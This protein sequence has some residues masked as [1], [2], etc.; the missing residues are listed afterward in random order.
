MTY[1]IDI[2]IQDNES[3][4]VIEDS[5]HN[6]RLDHL[7][8]AFYHDCILGLESLLVIN[9]HNL[10]IIEHNIL[11]SFTNIQRALKNNIYIKYCSLDILIYDRHLTTQVHI[12]EDDIYISITIITSIVVITEE[13]IGL[14]NFISRIDLKENPYIKRG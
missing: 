12:L 7:E 2:R 1:K 13:K 11:Q 14:K 9:D 6:H 5:S 4:I 10:F 3:M 8:E